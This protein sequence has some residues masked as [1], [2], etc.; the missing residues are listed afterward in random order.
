VIIFSILFGLGNQIGSLI[1]NNVIRA[2]AA[3]FRI[4]PFVLTIVVMV[5]FSK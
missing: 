4:L 2:N 5:I 1:N 3:I